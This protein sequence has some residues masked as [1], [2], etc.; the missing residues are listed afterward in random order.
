MCLC[1]GTSVFDQADVFRDGVDI[2]AGT[3]FADF[4]AT[5]SAPAVSPASFPAEKTARNFVHVCL[6]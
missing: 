1:L 4:E 6:T 3:C 2:F 5:F